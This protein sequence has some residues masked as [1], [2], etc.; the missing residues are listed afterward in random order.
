MILQALAQALVEVV[1]LFVEFLRVL[2]PGEELIEVSEF[3]SDL[4]LFKF[5]G[6]ILGSLGNHLLHLRFRLLLGACALHN[7][8]AAGGLPLLLQDA[9]HI[10]AIQECVALVVPNVL[11]LIAIL[12]ASLIQ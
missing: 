2:D 8:P 10:T 12:N 7:H 1:L 3:A 6:G 9:D 5:G 4:F 11:D